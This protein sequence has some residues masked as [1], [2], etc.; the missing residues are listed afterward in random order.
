[1]KETISRSDARRI[2]LASQGLH[3]VRPFGKGK[4]AVLAAIEH[5]GYVQIDTISVTERAHDHVLWS[6]VPDYQKQYLQRLQQ[7]DRRVF[8]FWAH[9]AAYL[10]MHEYRYCIPIMRYFSHHHDSWPKSDRK[11]MRYVLDRIRSEGAMKSRDFE[12]P[13]IT[14]ATGWWDWKPTK[15]AL[16][17]LFFAGDLMISHRE[18]FQRVYDLPER[19]LPSGIITTPPTTEEYARYLVRSTIRAHGLIRPGEAAYLRKGMGAPVRKALQEM[20]GDAELLQLKV[21]G[22]KGDFYTTQE[23]LDTTMRMTRRPKLLS[24]FDNGVI[25][26]D[27]LRDLF[28]FDY[29]VEIYLPAPKRKYG[30]YCLP[31]L[32]GDTFIGRVDVKADRKTRTLRLIHVHLE[33]VKLTE[34]LARQLGIAFHEFARFNQCEHLVLGRVTPAVWKQVLKSN[35]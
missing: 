11:T 19:I 9:A 27:R 8:E 15:L 5:L 35:L 28:D 30:Y 13:P 23:A 4:Q 12:A 6:R 33:T 32:S 29:Q 17:R 2:A 22:V 21:R 14:G 24:P 18:G 7:R 16:Q 25:Q 34:D 26:R 3:S 31:I 1:M 20:T 10:P